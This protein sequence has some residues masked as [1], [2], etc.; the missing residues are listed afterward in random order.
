MDIS[1]C[2]A[3]KSIW[4]AFIAKLSA[5]A[6]MGRSTS[7]FRSIPG[8]TESPRSGSTGMLRRDVNSKLLLLMETLLSGS[9]G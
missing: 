9:Y 4:S 6:D 8:N 5:A 7:K 2:A 1:F 3:R